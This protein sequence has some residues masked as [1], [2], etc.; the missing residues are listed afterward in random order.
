MYKQ[1]LAPHYI[2]KNGVRH[3]T[4]GKRN[5]A[6]VYM[7]YQ[8]RQLVYVGMSSNNLY[9]TMYRHLQDWSASKQYRAVYDPDSVKIR[10][11][12]CT[13]L[14]A[15]RLEKALIIK[16]NPVGNKNKYEQYT[17]DYNEKQVYQQYI[18]EETRP[19]IT[20]VDENYKHPF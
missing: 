17:I 12:Y 16:H 8:D 6:G 20:A 10:V 1:K 5:T 9:R 4:F 14:Q 3:T 11:I 7:I 18:E 15:D 13:P 2:Y 19:I